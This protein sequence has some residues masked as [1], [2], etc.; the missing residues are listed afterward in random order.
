MDFIDKL[1]DLSARI[2]NQLEHIQTEEATK[3]GLIMPFISTLGYNVF[4]PTEVMP[5]FCADVGTK[6]GEK[7]DYAIL[8][9][10]QPILL[11]ECKWHGCDLSKEHASQL[12]RYFSVTDARFSILTN[13][14][15]YR[16]YTDLDAPNKMDSKPFFEFNILEV[17][18]PDV[19][20]LKK[21]T[22]SI[23]DVQD[24]L[25]T[26]NELKYTR[27]IKRILTE[28]LQEPSDEFVKFF[29]TQVYA[30]R[31]TQTVREQFAQTTK[32]AF[33]SFVHD[34]INERLRTALGNDNHVTEE[35]NDSSLAASSTEATS[36]AITTTDEERTAYYIVK[37]ILRETVDVKRIAMRDQQTYCSILL[38]D[39]NRK[40]IC[41]L[42][43]N[44]K[45]KYIGLFDNE[46]R[47]E[48]RETLSE[49]DEIYSYAERL[50]ATVALYGNG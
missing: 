22:K 27:E 3:N 15:I 17:R 48:S 5:E 26:A 47:K 49:L 42:W 9:D 14:L 50:Q 23:F 41:R 32:R 37:A 39:N 34:Q 30:G 12:Y 13:G 10:G 38:D 2:P 35:T 31:M 20:E 18:E 19:D 45:Q 43:F 33:K 28:Q 7:V 40:P 21:F 36:A 44:R 11:F 46:K 24:I 8:R 25:T 6:K 16:F 29:A 4:D 1:R